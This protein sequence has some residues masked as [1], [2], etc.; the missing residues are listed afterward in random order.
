MTID[1]REFVE[2]CPICQ[3]EKTDDTLARGQ[4]QNMQLPVEKWQEVDI[5]FATDLPDTGDGINSIMT[6]IDKANRM[7]H[8]IHCRKSISATETERLYMRYIAKLHGV[9]RDI[10]TDR[11]NQFISKFWREIWGLLGT[12]LRYSTAYHPQTQGIVER[13]NAV[14]I[15]LFKCTIQEMNELRNGRIIYLQLNLQSIHQ[16]TAA[17]DTHHS[18]L[19][20]V[21]TL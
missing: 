16:W 10:Y 6:V 18:F 1:V 11:G 19:I 9:P 7:I 21:L 15:Q 3:T 13:M 12:S 8:L 20:M 5:D 4:L 14:V 2:S 17:L